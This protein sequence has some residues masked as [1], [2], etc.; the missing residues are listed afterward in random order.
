MLFALGFHYACAP[1]TAVPQSAVSNKYLEEKEQESRI[2]RVQNN[3]KDQ[4]F[5]IQHM[6]LSLSFD[7]EE[8]RVDGKAELF[9]SPYFYSQD[10]ILLDAKRFIVK[11][12]QLNGE[13]VYTYTN[14]SLT[15]GVDFDRLYKKDEL[16]KIEISYSC[17]PDKTRKMISGSDGLYFVIDDNSS[18]LWTQG[19]TEFGSTWF[20]TIEDTRQRLTHDIFL[21]VDSSYYTLS[22]GLLVSSQT[23]SLGMRID[24]WRMDQP[25][26]PYLVM[27][28]AGDFVR[29]QEK[30]G[31]LTDRGDL[32]IEYYQEKE[33]S[34]ATEVIFQNTPE[35]I[36]FF[37]S[38]FGVK[39]PWKKYSQIVVHDF[40]TGAMENT[41]ASVF[42][43][44]LNTD[45]KALTERSYDDIIA[46]ELVHQW[47]G[48]LVTCEDW[49]SIALNE[50]FATYG[51]Y[52]W[53]ENN[54]GKMEAD[55]HGY[56]ELLDYL[57]EAKAKT[58]PIIW[59][60]Y[61]NANEDIFDNHSYAKASRV[62]HMLR[63]LVGDEAFWLALE[64]YLSKNQFKSV[65]I[66]DLKSSFESVTGKD[67]S[68]FFEQWFLMEG[69]PIVEWQFSDSLY[70]RINFKQ[71][72]ETGGPFVFELELD[73][74]Y[75]EGKE[76]KMIPFNSWEQELILARSEKPDAIILDPDLKLL[77]EE[78]KEFNLREEMRAFQK[79]ENPVKKYYLGLALMDSLN[80]KGS[81]RLG[82]TLLGDSLWFIRNLG[83]NMIS[84]NYD[85]LK[86]T[87][88]E[89]NRMVSIVENDIE[90]INRGIALE[91]LPSNERF[92]AIFLKGIYDTSWYVN[93]SSMVHLL[94]FKED[95]FLTEGRFSL[96]R[97]SSD[98]DMIFAMADYQTKF[99]PGANQS[100]LKSK[101]DR[102]GR[103]DVFWFYDF[104]I[105]DFDSGPEESK[106]GYEDWIRDLCL[107]SSDRLRFFLLSRLE[108]CESAEAKE[109]YDECLKAEQNKEYQEWVE[110]K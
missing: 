44:G 32:L 15:I 63:G 46:H 24:H 109:L 78:K 47:F 100:W 50:G 104:V 105:I 49:A 29:F 62:L 33:S 84:R 27:I 43:D 75:K 73:L 87:E 85:S 2:K 45:L 71:I 80:K 79:A 99:F 41:S 52:I 9:L 98:L 101:V 82:H 91:L 23:D 22:N 19:E 88:K 48:D 103:W 64:D 20:P 97:E 30:R 54:E 72:Q 76:R 13:K 11:D 67:L 90:P 35:M 1:K 89:E 94:S 83:L 93:A 56:S 37:N 96:F 5:D 92:E 16:I 17:F 8:K 34:D 6:N 81:E 3:R 21:K 58:H 10:K 66:W 40:V 65:S 55:I 102:L 107:N 69:H 74:F 28:A 14:D 108:E 60:D 36:R 12:L 77:F 18:E 86:L 31:G 68:T 39:Y 26:P 38:K 110:K 53:K 59:H 51:E 106:E 7:W 4:L 57:Y 61:Y 42:H 25:H 95:P 70:T